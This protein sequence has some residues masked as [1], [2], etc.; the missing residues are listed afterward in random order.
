MNNIPELSKTKLECLV[1]EV[2]LKVGQNI[3][4]KSATDRRTSAGT[5][6]DFKHAG[7]K[8]E[9]KSSVWMRIVDIQSN[10]SEWVSVYVW[11]CQYDKGMFGNKK[12]EVNAS[13]ESPTAEGYP[14]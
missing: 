5:I 2:T 13:Q 3:D 7:W 1:D 10:D 11:K 6:K 14:F 12:T 4:Y 8:Q 9:D